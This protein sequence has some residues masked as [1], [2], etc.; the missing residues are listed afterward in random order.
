MR[1]GI[2]PSPKFPFSLFEEITLGKKPPAGQPS[3]NWPQARASSRAESSI[4]TKLI[5]LAAMALL[6][7]GLT[8]A[9]STSA[10]SDSSNSSKAKQS[11]SATTPAGKT[12]PPNTTEP[13]LPSKGKQNTQEGAPDTTIR[14]RQNSTT[15]TTG[16]SG[17]SETHPPDST[18]GTTGT[19]PG[20]DTS[21]SG[22]KSGSNPQSGSSP[23]QQ[24]NSSTTPSAPTPHLVMNDTPGARAMATH[25]P[26]PGTCMSPAALEA[27]QY[28]ANVPSS[29]RRTS[30]CD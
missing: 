21:Q 11:Q 10:P 16:A 27:G 6:G 23:D 1:E 5:Y 30:A 4:M 25:T 28:Q 20:A 13:N 19:T 29:H 14:D 15:S 18:M 22:A 17:Q 12:A 8:M 7:L 24:P 9:Q 3:S 2:L 26:D